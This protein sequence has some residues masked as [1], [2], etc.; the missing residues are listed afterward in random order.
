MGKAGL[1]EPPARALVSYP[2]KVSRGVEMG[3]VCR[4]GGVVIF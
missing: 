2:E 3:R 4:A 1:G